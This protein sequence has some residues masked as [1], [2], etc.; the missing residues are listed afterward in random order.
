[1]NGKECYYTISEESCPP[2]FELVQ[3]STDEVQTGVLTA[4][5]KKTKA[6]VNVIKID[7]NSK[8]R[9][10][11]ATFQLRSLDP[12]QIGAKDLDGGVVKTAT[13]GGSGTPN[14]GKVSFND[15]DPG[16]Y[17]IKETVV[18]EGYVITGSDAF[19]IKVTAEG[20][21]RISL[22]PEKKPSEWSTTGDDATITFSNG[23]ATVSNTPG[24]ALPNSGGPGTGI[25]T[26]LGL[27]LMAAAGTGWVMKERRAGR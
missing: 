5:N 17:E 13:T 15:I 10:G 27:L 25:Y 23:T 12:N 14:Y 19:Y 2:G 1:M 9:L 16:F 7:G 11:G 22:D 24:A 26:L 3:I 4:Y 8:A 6:D 18:P 21:Y 20:I